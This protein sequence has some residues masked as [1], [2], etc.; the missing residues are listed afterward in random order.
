MPR[1]MRYGKESIKG[2]FVPLRYDVITSDAFKALS[3]SAVRVLILVMAQFNGRNNGNIIVT[4]RQLEA[5]GQIGHTAATRALKELQQKG[6]LV[7]TAQGL[8]TTKM[9]NTWE[10]TIVKN[11]GENRP[12]DK[13]KEWRHGNDF[14]TPMPFDVPI[15]Q[16]LPKQTKVPQNVQT[17]TQKRT[18]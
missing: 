15:A 17:R 9:A 16:P 6:F 11:N 18:T 7:K 2:R 4:S 12:S 8:Y 13:F 10:I 3:H 5:T 14:H 1:K